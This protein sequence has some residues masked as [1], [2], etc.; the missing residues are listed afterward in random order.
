VSPLRSPNGSRAIDEFLSADEAQQVIGN[1]KK[2][3]E[4]I[5]SGHSVWRTLDEHA[6]DPA[7][8][9]R[10]KLEFPIGAEFWLD[11]PSRRAF[12]KTMG[13]SFA[14][15]GLTGCIRQPEETITP[16]VQTPENMVPGR[17]QHYATAMPQPGGAIG[18]LVQT[19]EG[20]PTKAEGNP[21]HPASRG[22]T[23]LFAQASILDLYD[24]HRSRVVHHFNRLSSWTDFLI[25]FG[26][27]LDVH[28]NQQ[29]QGFA[30]LTGEILS[31][32]LQAQMARWK[33]RFPKAKWYQYE[34]WESEPAAEAIREAFGEP[35][36]PYFDLR[37]ADV[38]LSVGSDFMGE[39]PGRVRLAREF[40]DRRRVE[41]S[42]PPALN[43]L[44][45]VES[46][47]TITGSKADH[48]LRL[49]PDAVAGLLLE[50]A[51]RLNIDVAGAPALNVQAAA[52][53]QKWVTALVSDLQRARGKSA[54]MVGTDQPAWVQVLG[55]AINNALGNIG[56]TLRLLPPPGRIP[57][58]DPL[59]LADL[60]KSLDAGE[61]QTLLILGQD[62]VYHAPADFEFAEKIKK[63]ECSI[64]AGH[65]VD[66]TALACEWHLPLTHF[67]EEWSDTQ[68]EDGT[69]SL[70]QPLIRPLY[71][72]RSC[73]EILNILLDAPSRSG[74]ETVREQWLQQFGAGQA[75]RWEQ[76]L[77]DG[78]VADTAKKPVNASFNSAALAN[79]KSPSTDGNGDWTVL[80]RMDPCLFD[81]RQ[82][83]NGW[84]Q[85]LPQP[86]S[87]LTWGNAAWISPKSAEELGLKTRDLVEVKTSSGSVRIPVW[88][89][90]GQPEKVLTLPLGHG[91][92]IQ[93]FEPVGVNVSAIRTSGGAWRTSGSVAPAGERVPLSMTQHHHLM[94]GRE[95]VRF[96]TWQEF[97][98][99]PDHLPFMPHESHDAKAVES[100]GEGEQ[101]AGEHPEGTSLFADHPHSGPQWGMSINLTA[102]TGCNA[103][104]VACQSENNI[105][106]V[107]ADQVQRGRE[108]HWLRIDSYF[109]GETE[110][111]DVYHQPV[112]CMHCEHAPC[113]IVCPVGATT[114]SDDGLNEMTYNR[115]IGTRYCS[116]NCPYKVRRFNFLDFQTQTKQLPVL[117]MHENPNVSVRSRGVMEKCTYC[118]QRIRTVDIHAQIEGRDIRDGEI[119]TA[120]QAVCPTQAITF[121]NIADSNSHVAQL[122]ANPLDYGMLTELNTRP[123]TSYLAALRN[124]HPDLVGAAEEHS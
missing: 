25:E 99:H 98:E 81:G 20:R 80:F 45:V 21:D 120:C 104:V 87:K 123:R 23:D 64:H 86:I 114:H 76:S 88:I 35:V 39:G 22:A 65:H 95:L 113:E 96:G 71:E 38:V 27:R 52:S 59:R 117:Q 83:T 116:N 66:A 105:P 54:V 89:Q 67:Y 68:A 32:T 43:R 40:M 3:P 94:E 9:E 118:V 33:A 97:K 15:A 6:A 50:I 1:G 62:V 4:R 108:M 106:V 82:C 85:E 102:C 122:K 30:I 79:I 16:Y 7:F 58:L 121:G 101:P 103:C 46:T 77:H 18:L 109:S 24:P 47:P 63:A 29:G 12:L 28:G 48:W 100:A 44:Y 11:E 49:S 70:M 93:G 57:D 19:H 5:E 31:P 53:Q 8:L 51:R 26:S 17:P 111:P 90:P 91:R 84:L 14:L 55:Y 78:V 112:M 13:A 2:Q 41:G 75:T 36:A 73:H 56:Q 37:A 74:Y 72:G 69:V 115:C 92:F 61:V 60:A 110:D 10:V 124:P 119:V 34:A 42:A 107:G